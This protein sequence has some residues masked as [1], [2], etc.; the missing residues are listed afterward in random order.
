MKVRT[1][2]ESSSVEGETP[3]LSGVPPEYH[4]FAD[5]FS[6]KKADT[7]PEHRPYDLKITLEEGK[8]PPL[9]PIYS[10]SQVELDTLR[11][12]IEE[13]L[14]SGFIRPSNSPCGA[15]VLFVK[16]KDGS[17]RLCVDYR[18]LNK[19]TRKDRYPLPLVSDLLDTPRKARIYTK[20]DLRHA[21]NLVRIAP[22]D[23]W[24]TAFRTRY[25]SFEWLVMPFGLSNA[26][27]AFQ[28]FVNEVFV[29]LLDVCVVVYLDD[30][31]IYSNSLEEHRQHVK[32][33]LRRLR[34]FKLYARADKCEFHATSVEYLGY[35]L[36]PEGLTMAESKVKAILDWPEPR[37]V[38]DIQSFLGFANFYRRFIHNYSEIVLPLTRLTRKGVPW[39]FDQRCR[40]S[41]NA[42]KKAFTSA[43]ILHHW[44]PDR[45]I[46]VETDAS[47]Y[48]IAGIL[49]ITTESG[50]LHPVAFHSR[51]LSGAE[52][53]YDTHD[54][55]LLAIF[56]CFKTWRHYLEGSGTPIDVVTDHKNLEYFSTTKLL[57]RRQARW[58]EFLSQFNLVIRFRPGKLGAKPDAL[59]RRWDVY[60]KEGGSD[61]SVV[62]P[63]NF[64]PVFRQEQLS[65]SLRAT[66]LWQ[67]VLRASFLM[68]DE[69]LQSDIRKALDSDSRDSELSAALAAAHQ[70]DSRWSRDEEGFLRFNGRIYVPD[71]S[72]LRLRVLRSRH[73][74]PTAGH[75]GQNKT[76]A[77]VLRNYAW[78]GLRAYVRDYMK[79]CT[80]CVRAKT[81]QHLPY[82]TLKQLPIPERPWNSISM[83]LIEQLPSSGGYTAILVVVDRL[84]KQA[85]FIPTHDTLT[86]SELADLFVMHVFS[87]HGVPSH[88]TSDRGSEFVSH[89]FRSLR[90]ALDMRLH[91]TSGY[92]P[93][94][95]GQTERVNQ[96]LEQY[97]RIYCNYQ[98]DNWARLLPLAEFAYN[99]APN[100]TT[101][102]SPF[103]ANKGYHPG[104]TVHPE[105]DLTSA[106][107]REF[108]VDLEELHTELRR[109]IAEAQARYQVQADKHRLPAPDFRIGDL[110]YLK[111]EHIRT[112]RPSKK[113]SEKFLG[114]FEIIA[115]VGTHS[116][117]LRLLDS[118]RAVHPVFH[119]SQLEPATLNVIPGRVQPPPPPV[120]VDGEPEYE[121]LE[122][123][124][125][126]L[127]RHRKTCKLLYLVCWAG[128]EG[129]DE[130]TLWIL[131]MELGHTQEL[132]SD[133]HRTYPDKPG[134]LE[135]VT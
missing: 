11:E 105:R 112:T 62:N 37:K 106:R 120:I 46:T 2:A 25:G 100:A 36:S 82:G 19:I 14:R 135:K 32:E 63:H 126:K 29:D 128:Y 101:G 72:D 57:T 77:L 12:Y 74:H 22:G 34:K 1:P 103:F 99:N 44:E 38:R 78:P 80:Q 54:K 121:I 53:N 90:K 4:E 98:Q 48:A 3:D 10:L 61:Y 42:L 91:F 20:I 23:E 76:Q 115:K 45:Q 64:R 60:P 125:S 123:L 134:P 83:D 108:A 56:E 13:N 30:I 66:Y 84:T 93:E 52:L 85:I 28:R 119:V 33:V 9:G 116:Y 129:T 130:E 68:D 111:A 118:M 6:K 18:G 97:L 7:L 110:V 71:V 122:I 50:E 8:V 67:P 117:T 75:W 41:F 65:A 81:P 16:K 94:G 79:S 17:L 124:D 51:T 113:L 132:V 131:A 5:V 49:S 47:D 26:P 69:Q 104:L 102:I 40:D 43:P 95:D 55:D 58:S 21:Y 127:D 107:A 114:P 109:Q 59:T 35:I 27:A 24:K 92:H 133:F 87:K 96:T 31:L 39:N 70:G 86:A 73:D 15:P 88:V 89:F